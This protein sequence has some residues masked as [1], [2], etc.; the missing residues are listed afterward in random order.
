M[1]NRRPFAATIQFALVILMLL[2]ILLLGQSFSLWGYKIGLILMVI[3]SLSQIAF[4]NIAPEV[5]LA[6]SMRYYLLY[7]GIIVALFVLSIAITPYLI[8]LGR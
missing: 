4:G 7:M 8:S 1:T 6:K 5:N 3:T 2:S